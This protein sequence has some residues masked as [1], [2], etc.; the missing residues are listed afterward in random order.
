MAEQSAQGSQNSGGN[1]APFSFAA[2][3]EPGASSGSE[4]PGLFDRNLFGGEAEDASPARRGGT[5]VVNPGSPVIDDSHSTKPPL[6]KP[7]E[8]ILLDYILNSRQGWGW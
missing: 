8:N 7:V 6:R 2:A 4:M 3:M 5:L 1:D